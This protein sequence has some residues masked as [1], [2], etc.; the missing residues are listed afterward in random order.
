MRMVSPL[1]AREYQVGL[2]IQG[3]IFIED[4]SPDFESSTEIRRVNLGQDFTTDQIKPCSPPFNH[5]NHA[6]TVVNAV[7]TTWHLAFALRT[8]AA[9][10]LRLKRKKY[11][12]LPGAECI[13]CWSTHD[14][15]DGI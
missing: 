10:P 1:L 13:M 9:F 14:T 4:S 3:V 6:G 2:A 8:C 5:E 7:G 12:K 11:D 15:S